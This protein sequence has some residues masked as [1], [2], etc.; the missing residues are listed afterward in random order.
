MSGV[1]TAI[2]RNGILRGVGTA[3]GL[4]SPATAMV[5]R[6]PVCH[7]HACVDSYQ[8]LATERD[9][10]ACR[11]CAF[12]ITQDRGVWRALRLARQAYF[13]QFMRE[14]ERVRKAEGRGSTLSK[15]YLA[16]PFQDITG[17]NRWQWSIRTKTYVYLVRNILPELQG[18]AGSSLK[19]LDLGAGNCW[20][21]HR[22]SQLGHRP[23]AVDLLTNEFDGLGAAVHYKSA[24]ATSF[25]R[26]HAELDEL[27]FGDE[28]FDCAIFNASFHYSESYSETLAETIRCLVPGGTLVIAD[29]PTYSNDTAGQRMVEERQTFFQKNFGFKSN[30]LASSEY[31][32]KERLQELAARH[33]FA[34]KTHHV[35][36]GLRWASRPMFSRLTKRREPSQFCV[37]TARV[38]EQ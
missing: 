30:G 20:L 12:K 5:L 6:C 35:W 22:L 17:N 27:P 33:H 9:D 36:Y 38:K 23:V 31:L 16:L 13:A 19:I 2:A 32:T 11:A 24:T 7:T 37:Y 4:A 8:S 28:Q 26:F 14:Y 29:S 34:W 1:S 21:S 18:K 10:V 25:P 15:F 3:D